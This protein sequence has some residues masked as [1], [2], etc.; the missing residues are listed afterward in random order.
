MALFANAA[1]RPSSSQALRNGAVS[2]GRCNTSSKPPC[3]SY[4]AKF[5]QGTDVNGT[6]LFRF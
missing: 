3:R 1:C 4:E 2:M 5:V 6:A